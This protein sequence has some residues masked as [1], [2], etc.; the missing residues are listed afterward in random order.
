MKGTQGATRIRQLLA[1]ALLVALSVVVV[2]C[3]DSNDSSSD[4]SSAGGEATAAE[5]GGAGVAKAEQIFKAATTRPTEA[6]IDTPIEKPIPGGKRIAFVSCGT[7]VC[8]AEADALTEASE[9]LGWSLDS[10]ETDGTPQAIQRAFETVVREKPDAV[11]YCAQ[12]ST[13]IG[14]MLKQLDEQDVFVAAC[15]TTDE[16]GDDGIDFTIDGAE[17][18]SRVGE[19]MAAWAVADSNGEGNAVWVQVPDFQILVP[20]H[21]RFNDT[22]KELCPEC[23]ADTLDIPLTSLLDGTGPNRIVSY[24]RGHSDVGHVALSIDGLG[25]GLP[26]ALRAAGLDDIQ[27]IGQSPSD[28]TIQQ[29]ID[30]TEAATGQFAMYEDMY[31][32]IDSIARDFAGEEQL[33]DVHPPVWFTTPENIPDEE[34][35]YPLVPNV[36]EKFAELWGKG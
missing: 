19:V 25:S 34:L 29:V 21:E 24:L 31:S 11:T 18:L 30:G 7:P 28:E 8:A 14:P 6:P 9:L 3:G 13:V 22:M 26:S 4:S 16:V 36:D 1:L 32:M 27:F 23:G 15:A 20:M 10:H 33:K 5:D 35:Y 12:D 17:D 2:A